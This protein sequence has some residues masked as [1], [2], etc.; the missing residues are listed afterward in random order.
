MH[1]EQLIAGHTGRFSDRYQSTTWPGS[2]SVTYPQ[3][4]TGVSQ[5]SQEEEALFLDSGGKAS[6]TGQRA[7]DAAGCVLHLQ[8]RFAMETVNDRGVH[9]ILQPVLDQLVVQLRHIQ[10]LRTGTTQYGNS[11]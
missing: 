11:S 4:A 6:V 8:R 10:Q 2:S 9:F 3:L 5:L 1:T 7:G